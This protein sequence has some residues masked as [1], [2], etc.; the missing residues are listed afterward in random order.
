MQKIPFL[1]RMTIRRK[2]SVVFIVLVLIPALIAGF[3]LIRAEERNITQ[4]RVNETET[5][6]HLMAEDILTKASQVRY[7]IGLLA[8]DEE[9]QPALLYDGSYGRFAVDM[10]YVVAPRLSDIS[11]Y[12]FSLNASVMLITPNEKTPE[13]YEVLMR[14]SAFEEQNIYNALQNGTNSLWGEPGWHM[15][16]GLMNGNFYAYRTIPFYQRVLRGVTEFIGVI[17]C[18]VWMDRLFSVLYTYEGSE[19]MMVCRKGRCLFSTADMPEAVTPISSGI[20]VYDG[21]LY[22]SIELADMDMYLLAQIPELTAHERFQAFT[23][24]VSLIVLFAVV[25]LLISHM[26][27]DRVLISL[28]DVEQAIDST[29]SDRP[30]ILLPVRGQDELSRLFASFNHLLVLRD[31]QARRIVEQEENIHTAQLLAL[32]CQVN[33]H[34]LFNALNWLQLTI[35]TGRINE[36]TSDAIAYLGLILHYN[37]SASNISTI[38]EE[39]DNLR[40][41]LSFMDIREPGAIHSEIVCPDELLPCAF[42]RF[43]LQ[44]IV[45]NAVCHG[46]RHGHELHL[47]VRFEMAENKIHL[48]IA[49][50]GVGLSADEVE[51][52]NRR[53]REDA[54]PASGNLGL[55][56]LAKRLHLLYGKAEVGIQCTSG[57]VIVNICVDRKVKEEQL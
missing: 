56:N 5:R 45:E 51:Q 15:P 12:L 2:I 52:I 42:L 55:Y 7:L 21:G 11:S 32:Q 53:L 8:L 54:P 38:S 28:K 57:Q 14:Q 6:L 36:Q 34:F 16:T 26:E 10:Q 47:S 41:Y 50:D 40:S 29:G 3:F 35:E 27:V 20:S 39:L 18:S 31:Q 1:N 9:L 24:S 44:P 17:K 37:M 19:A 4:N 22:L 48:V 43:S 25:I 23:P 13:I 30:D 49:N 46:K 33:P